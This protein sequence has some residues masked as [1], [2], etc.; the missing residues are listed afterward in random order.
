MSMTCSVALVSPSDVLNSVRY[1]SRILL[2]AGWQSVGMSNSVWWALWGIA[3]GQSS[4]STS[5]H[6][7]VAFPFNTP[8]SSRLRKVPFPKSITTPCCLRKSHPIM[9]GADNCS[10]TMNAWLVMKLSSW[11]FT[12]LVPIEVRPVP[13]AFV[14]LIEFKGRMLLGNT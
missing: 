2:R 4:S 12:V 7:V 14:S 11:T 3:C 13:S 9:A 1:S 5:M 8:E 10:T 6:E